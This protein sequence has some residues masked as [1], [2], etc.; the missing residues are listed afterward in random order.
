MFLQGAD[1]FLDE[2]LENSLQAI[3]SSEMAAEALSPD[4]KG[5]SKCEVING[6]NLALS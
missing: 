5:A 4:D 3:E 6:E 2:T 1:A